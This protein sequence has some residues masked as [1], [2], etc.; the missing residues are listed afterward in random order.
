M[1]YIRLKSVD[2]DIEAFIMDLVKQNI[3]LREKNNVS[4]KDLFQLLIQLRNTGK[5]EADGIWDTNYSTKTIKQLTINE[6]AAQAWIFYIAGF[7]TSTT[8]TSFCL[9]E[10][11]NN[12]KIQQKVQLEIDDIIEKFNGQISYE[13]ISEMKYLEACIDGM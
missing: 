11:A 8:T 10:L 1:G 7:E 4:R 2:D 3:E 9:Y 13:C 12:P 5:V 6:M